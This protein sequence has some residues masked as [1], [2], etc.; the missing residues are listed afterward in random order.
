LRIFFVVSLT[1]L[2]HFSKIITIANFLPC[3]LLSHSRLSSFIHHHHVR[4]LKIG[5]SSAKFICNLVLIPGDLHH[6]TV[7][8]NQ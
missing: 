5:I 8:S 6:I 3:S 7:Y 2:G 4:G 1:F